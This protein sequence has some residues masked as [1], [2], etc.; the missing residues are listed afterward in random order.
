MTTGLQVIHIEKR[1]TISSGLNRHIT[2]QQ[3]VTVGENRT[4]EVWVPD[5]ADSSK[6]EYNVELISREFIDSQGQK[7]DLTLQQA[8]DKR[9]HEAEIK[10][11]KGQA[12][13]LE[14]IFSGSHDV[15]AAMSKAELKQWADDTLEWALNTWGKENVVSAS[16]H[17]DERTP[18]IHMIVVPIVTGQSRRTRNYKMK[19]ERRGKATKSYNIDH[20]K[21]RLCV[22]EVYTT[23]KL[24]EYHDNYAKEVSQKYGL[25]RGV[26]AEPGSKKKHTNSIEYNRMLAK[27][28]TELQALIEELT[29]DYADKKAEL[30]EEILQLKNNH[31]TLS[32]A[33][34]EEEEKKK[35]AEAKAKEAERKS[36]EAEERLSSQ[37]KMINTNTSLINQQIDDYLLR[38]KELKQTETYIT[39]NR[40]TISEQSD[41]IAKNQDYLQELKSIEDEISKKKDELKAFSSLGLLK[42]IMALYNTVIAEIQERIKGYW[43]G[44]VT[45]YKEVQHAVGDGSVEDFAKI[46]I[47]NGDINYSIEVSVKTG[48]VYADGKPEP[49]KWKSTKEEMLMPELAEYFRTELTP[50]AKQFAKDLFKKQTQTQKKNDQSRQRPGRSNKMQK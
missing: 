23:G 34:K 21:L 8:V 36:K 26:K 29:S 25:D 18:H 2:R 1:I 12:T 24:Y 40:K 32:A 31:I 28:A 20:K 6:T 17:V 46:Y 30:Q 10:P 7:Y 4:V 38:S 50:E 14:I 43:N 27:Q 16:L 42:M 15:M 37:E 47:S 9:I 3:F 49:I 13:C 22:N 11:R 41:E 19:A 35:K 44:N 5:N 45:S 39:A 48:K 33:V